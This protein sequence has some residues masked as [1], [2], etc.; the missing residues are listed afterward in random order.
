MIENAPYKRQSIDWWLVGAYLLLVLIGWVN[1]YAATH[2][3]EAGSL[4]DFGGRAGKQF[5]WILT[6]LGLAVFILYLL[7]ARLWEAVTIPLYAVVLGLLVLVIFVS[8]NIKGSHSWFSLGPISFQPAEISKI[9]T[10]LLL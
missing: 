7:P 10:S 8:S 3:A 6:A 2:T 1:I 9:S 5:V 4:L